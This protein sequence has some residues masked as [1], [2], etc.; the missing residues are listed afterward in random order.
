MSELHIELH[1]ARSNDA[2]VVGETLAALDD[3]FRAVA[4]DITG[5]PDA[6][7]LVVAG[8]SF[9]CDGCGRKVKKLPKTWVKRGSDDLCP[10]CQ[11]AVTEDAKER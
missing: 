1:G 8:F 7:R 9:K 11:K 10:R 4:E 3:L 6:V 5:H 2:R